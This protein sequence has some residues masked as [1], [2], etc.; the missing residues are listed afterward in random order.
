MSAHGSPAV[1]AAFGGCVCGCKRR[2]IAPQTRDVEA[3]NARPL[4]RNRRAN[5]PVRSVPQSFPAVR[6]RGGSPVPALGRAGG[7]AVHGMA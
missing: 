1:K 2:A 7:E 6:P 4:R 5:T 3:V